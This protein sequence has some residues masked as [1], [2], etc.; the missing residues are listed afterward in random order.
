MSALR[1]EIL[2]TLI[3]GPGFGLEIHDR[4]RD[5]GLEGLVSAGAIYPVLRELERDGM[6]TSFAG[7]TTPARGGRPRIYYELTGEGRR[8]AFGEAEQARGWGGV[9]GVVPA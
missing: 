3:Q 6:L 9:L 5:R 4:L 1:Q 7:E 8:V 2:A